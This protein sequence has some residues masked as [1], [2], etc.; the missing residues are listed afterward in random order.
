MTRL[1]RIL[2]SIDRMFTSRSEYRLSIR[3]DNADVRLTEKGEYTILLFPILSSLHIY[4]SLPMHQM[5]LQLYG[6][7]VVPFAVHLSENL[8]AQKFLSIDLAL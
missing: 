1:C 2:K 6:P 5:M 7:H 4:W 3:A 8:R